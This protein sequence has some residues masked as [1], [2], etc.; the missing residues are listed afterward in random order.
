MK[1]EMKIMLFALGMS[2]AITGCGNA[3]YGDSGSE[4]AASESAS[5]IE[6][7]SEVEMAEDSSAKESSDEVKETDD[8]AE[9]NSNTKNVEKLTSDSAEQVTKQTLAETNDA[10]E[11]TSDTKS[12]EEPTADTDSAQQIAGQQSDV[13]V[14][15][16]LSLK[17]SGSTFTV[18]SLKNVT[19]TIV[20]DSDYEVTG[21]DRYDLEKNK[22]GQWV[23]VPLSFAWNDIGI[24]IPAHSSHDFECD[25]SRVT[26]YETGTSYRLVKTVSYDQ[27]EYQCHSV[28]NEAVIH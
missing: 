8:M 5:T 15:D 10:A 13:N 2:T 27:T 25:L 28:R 9:E 7:M 11:E 18:E 4:S 23:S 6:A 12:V 3:V 16:A 14:S 21:G 26:S 24:I 20:N 22:N 1:K 17:L 19:V